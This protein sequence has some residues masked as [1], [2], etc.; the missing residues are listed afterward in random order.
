MINK[1]EKILK[2]IGNT[3]TVSDGNGIFLKVE[4]ENPAGSIKDRVAAYIILNAIKS[5][6]INKDTKV[7]EATS[8]NTGIGLAYVCRELGISC[9]IYMPENMS[10]KRR[11][12]ISQYGAQIILTPA[13]DG[14]KGSLERGIR[15]CEK[16]RGFFADQFNN[17]SSIQAHY[18]TTAKE[19]FNERQYEYIVCGIGTG[20]TAMGIKRYIKDNNINCK[21]VG[22]EP[23]Q[24]PL[25]SGGIASSHKIEGIGANFIP[26]IINVADLDEIRTVDES[27]AISTVSEMYKDFG[28]KCGISSAASYL[29]AKELR[30]EGKKNIL[31]I[32]PDNGDR[33]PEELYK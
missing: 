26:S 11:T 2:K 21:V 7:I 31:I 19:I 20:G 8:G 15:D 13:K 4:G 23:K 6:L 29:I 3:K 24:S 18:E 10:E 1:I 17:P 12:C 16:C 27:L 14:M 25:L 9:A 22:V 28:F 30:D 32:C 33:Y 5:G